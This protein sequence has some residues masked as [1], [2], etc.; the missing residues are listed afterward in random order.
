M[1][2]ALKTRGIGTRPFFMGMHAQPAFHDLGLFI[3][4]SYPGSDLAY[5]YGFYLPSGL[6]LTIEQVDEVVA[7]VK[8]AIQELSPAPIAV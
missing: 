5:Q 6:T 7:C 4:E 1:M 3:N 8:N 2:K